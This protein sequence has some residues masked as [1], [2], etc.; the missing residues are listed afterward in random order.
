MS[1]VINTNTASSNATATLGSTNGAFQQSLQRLSSGSKIIK[2][3][4]DAGG[5]AV[6][7]KMSSANNRTAVVQS[8]V[9]NALSF[10]QTQDGALK[11]VAKILD[12]MSELKMMHTDGTKSNDDKTNY[13]TEFKALQ[14][15]LG[16]LAA[17]KFNGVDL[18][19]AAGNI[20]VKITEDGAKSVSVTQAN[21][22][23]DNGLK[24]GGVA[25][26]DLTDATNTI[27][28]VGITIDN[29]ITAI[30]NIATMRAQNGA[31]SSQLMFANE[32]LT[33][34]KTNIEA[35]ISR[36]MDTDIA[37]E[38][39]RFARL[40]IL[41]QAGTSMLAQANSAPQIALKLIG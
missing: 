18:F 41:T 33:I 22:A 4:D 7:M 34:N 21:L 14:T 31:E 36:I 20:D 30:Q 23:G 10:L 6:A 16:N 17:E 11:T 37:A 15:Q 19:K 25:A 28:S 27:D 38:S 32:M 1:L 9:G 5:L 26:N 39:T 13:Q 24:V 35:S 8:N 2:P 40:N 29:I 12:R 3:S